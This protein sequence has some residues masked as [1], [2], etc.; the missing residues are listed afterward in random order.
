[1]TDTEILDLYLERSESAISQTE[2]K[3][4]SYCFAIANGILKNRE[5]SNECVNEAYLKA[6]NSIPPQKPKVFSTFLGRITRNLAFDK[7]RASNAQKRGGGDTALLL[8][9]LEECVP[10]AKTI[11][12]ES[13]NNFLKETLNQFLS[14][15]K[16][17]DCV[18]FVQRYWYSNSIAEIAER[19]GVS[20]GQ[21][22]M[23]L[24]RTR[25]KLKQHLEKEGIMI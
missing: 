25:A 9:E 5:D 17:E 23:N 1:M 12:S 4:G 2:E 8:S 11:E 10:S 16:E 20:Q 18:F 21:V 22:T 7:Y 6:W 24:H 3:Y 14:S 13:E 15:I 19:H